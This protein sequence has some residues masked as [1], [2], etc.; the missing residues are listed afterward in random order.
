LKAAQQG[1]PPAQTDLADCYYNGEGCRADVYEAVSWY[2]KAAEQGHAPAQHALANCWYRGE[3]ASFT[4]RKSCSD[5]ELEADFSLTSAVILYRSAA[6]LGY[7]PSQCRL[8]DMYMSGEGVTKDS[9][10][11]LALYRQAAEHG[12]L[13]AAVKLGNALRLEGNADSTALALEWYRR[14][15]TQ[16]YGAAEV[17]LGDCYLR[18]EGVLADASTAVQWFLKAADKGEVAAFC[19]LG[20]CA[21]TAAE[22]HTS[23]PSASAAT[24]YRKA[25]ELGSAE[26]QHALVKPEYGPHRMGLGVVHSGSAFQKVAL[27]GECFYIGDGLELDVAQAFRW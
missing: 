4:P 17:A 3:C 9:V 14:A 25:A 20:D 6:K 2:R 15:A 8:A 19:R 16:S 22:L 27:Q 12:H 10:Q 13:E 21:D 1:Y 11:G 5:E 7:P 23:A 18:G 24:W 26:G